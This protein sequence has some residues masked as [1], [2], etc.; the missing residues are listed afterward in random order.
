MNQLPRPK[1]SI[2]FFTSGLSSGGLD[3]QIHSMADVF[4][5]HGYR[6]HI[7]SLTPKSPYGTLIKQSADLV[8]H[9]PDNSQNTI[10]IAGI[11]K[12]SPTLVRV[13]FQQFPNLS[14][15]K[16]GLGHIININISDQYIF[17]KNFETLFTQL[18]ADNAREPIVFVLGFSYQ[19]IRFLHTIQSELGI[20]AKYIEISSPKWRAAIRP[21]YPDEIQ[22][23]EKIDD[24]I[25]PSKTIGDELLQ[26]YKQ[27]R[28]YSVV[29]LFL[30]LP[31]L[32]NSSGS[33]NYPKTYGVAARLS[34]EKNQ[35]LLIRIMAIIKKTSPQESIRLVLVGAG[36]MD[37]KLHSLVKKLD[38]KD[39]VI[40]LGQIDAI[41]E[42]IDHI[43]VVVLLSDV[44]SISATLLE[45]LYYRKPIIATDV[46]ATK[47]LLKDGFNGYLIQDK[48]D[49]NGIAQ[50]VASILTDTEKYASM[51]RNS[52]TIYDASYSEAK[53][54]LEK[55]FGI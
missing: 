18:K 51:A 38:L 42:F 35:D 53:K 33:L 11:L 17:G 46:G 25:V 7:Y 52:R 20:T 2:A 40:F 16:K 10:K 1:Q 36:P 55:Y 19:T 43:G 3:R 50:K 22:S 21:A 44:E 32:S 45:S 30:K 8:I 41:Q 23:L 27:T 6:I 49:L 29:P 37:K 48:N 39:N 54:Q 9:Y 31:L 12:T 14:A 13:V 28:S 34:P 47:D 24:I 26:Y 5:E 4:I 15:I